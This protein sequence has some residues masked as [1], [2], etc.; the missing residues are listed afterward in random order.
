V[1]GLPDAT[2]VLFND[3]RVVANAGVLLPA[4]PADRLGVEALADRTVDLGDRAAAANPGREVMTL[5]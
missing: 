4:M 5:A 2:R 1:N 3:E